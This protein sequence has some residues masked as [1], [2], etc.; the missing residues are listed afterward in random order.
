MIEIL[1]L[2]TGLPDVNKSPSLLSSLQ[3]E[4]KGPLDVVMGIV[5]MLNLTLMAA[6]AERVGHEARRREA[7]RRRRSLAASLP[8]DSKLAPCMAGT[9]ES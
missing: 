2:A 7:A 9:L 4:V 6:M 1:P 5:V 8:R 3:H